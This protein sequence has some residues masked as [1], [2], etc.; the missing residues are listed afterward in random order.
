MA[1]LHLKQTRHEP[2]KRRSP[3]LLNIHRPYFDHGRSGVLRLGNDGKPL[4]AKDPPQVL[5]VTLTPDRLRRHNT[6]NPALQSTHRLLLRWGE[7]GGTGLPNPE[8]EIRETHYDPLPPDLQT[9]VEV[10]VGTSPWELL[11]RKWY[12]T[13]LTVRELADSFCVAKSQLYVDWSSSLWY[14]RGRF[15]TAD[16]HE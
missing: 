3:V 13:T 11:T 2:R 6:L 9:A 12:R 14:Y 8:A 16:V 4:R 1:T 10:I 15:D 5:R 7:S